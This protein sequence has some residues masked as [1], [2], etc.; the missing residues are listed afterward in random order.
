MMKTKTLRL[1]S[2]VTLVV[3]LF[4]APSGMVLAADPVVKISPAAGTISVDQIVVVSVTVEDVTSLF[5]AE[6]HITFDPNL[7]EVVDADASTDGLQIGIG[8]FLAADF[9]AQNVADNTAGKVDFGM[10]QMAPH[11]A[12]SGSGT[13]ATISFKG[14]GSGTSNVAFTN[15]LLADSGGGQIAA[16]AQNGTVTVTGGATATPTTEA[17]TA[18]PTTAPT[19]VTPVPSTC[20][21]QGYHTVR[22]GESLY[23][24][25]RAYATKPLAI[26]SCNGIVNPSSIF[27]GTQLGIPVAP[28]SPIPAGPIAV[29]QFTPGS[30]PVPTPV[31]TPGCR[32]YHTVALGDTLTAIAIRYGSNV[33]SIGTANS[34]VNLNLIFPGQVLCIP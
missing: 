2:F 21:F 5:G 16:S 9:I 30:G 32:Y 24:I 8:D 25:G 14:K 3:A 27:V 4:G 17:P 11:G 18:T 12:V 26:A 15:I 23:S 13:L 7:V 33:W 19:T 22:A 31:P 29:A 6:F 10:S 34:I 28:W 20:T 1:L